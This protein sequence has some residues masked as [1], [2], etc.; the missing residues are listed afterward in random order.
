[1]AP[2]S[3]ER[4]AWVAKLTRSF[5]KD[6]Y[7]EGGQKEFTSFL[8]KCSKKRA[9]YSWLTEKKIEGCLEKMSAPTIFPLILI[10]SNII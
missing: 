5:V 3:L 10:V 4:H 2:T 8:K 9:G 7:L 1:M 6:L